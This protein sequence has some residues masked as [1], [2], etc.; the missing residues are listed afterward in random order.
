MKHEKL[1]M[2]QTQTLIDFTEK[3]RRF[4][5]ANV[6]WL[7]WGWNQKVITDKSNHTFKINLLVLRKEWIARFIILLR[8]VR[9][10]CHSR[11]MKLLSFASK[12]KGLRMESI[13][14]SLFLRFKM[15]KLTTQM[16]MCFKLFP[17]RSCPFLRNYRPI[18]EDVCFT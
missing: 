16:K 13:N 2:Y 15:L 14:F 17:L 5:R 6:N 8:T 7:S 9:M 4:G 3:K 18:T 11:I 12:I 1:L 10:N